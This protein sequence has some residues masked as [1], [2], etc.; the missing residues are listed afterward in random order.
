M[1]ILTEIL[2]CIVIMG[3]ILYY[4]NILVFYKY[5]VILVDCC[6]IIL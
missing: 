2:L 4:L 6:P 1:L 3:T 5:T